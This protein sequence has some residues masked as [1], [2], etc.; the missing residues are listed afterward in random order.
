MNK[1]LLPV[2]VRRD[3]SYYTRIEW[4]STTESDPTFWVV[5][6]IRD[7]FERNGGTWG[8][9]SEDKVDVVLSFFGESQTIGK[10]RIF[11]NVGLD[12]SVLEELA[13]VINIYISDT[14]EP[15]KLRRKDDKIDDVSWTLIKSQQMKKSEGWQEIA[16][17]NAVEAKYIR[18]ELIGNFCTKENF[19]P[20]IET[21]EIKIYPKK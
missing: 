7:D 15:R 16:L 18:F 19:I 13:K 5:N 2:G 9:N 8:A 14:D 1:E 11:K 3:G 20:W 17:D 6:L 10:I 12:I 21:S 4:S